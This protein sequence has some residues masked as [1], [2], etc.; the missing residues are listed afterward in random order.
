M[1]FM[2]AKFIDFILYLIKRY[3]YYIGKY[4]NKNAIMFVPHSSMCRVDLYD[5]IK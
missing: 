1:N 5:I 3:Y 4:A 2:L